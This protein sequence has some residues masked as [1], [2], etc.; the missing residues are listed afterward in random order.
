M[1]DITEFYGEIPR[2]HPRRLPP[3]YAQRCVNA[4][5]ER[6]TLSPYRTPDNTGVALGTTASTFTQFAGAF[7][8]FVGDVDAVPG[9]VA[10]DRL[11]YTGDGAPKVRQTDGT[12]FNLSLGSPSTPPATALRNNGEYLTIDG[13]NVRLAHEIRGKGTGV[14]V[15]ISVSVAYNTATVRIALHTGLNAAQVKTIID[16]LKYQN[17][18]TTDTIAKSL[19]IVR[20]TSLRDEGEQTYDEDKNALGSPVRLID[21]VG[22][23]VSV[24]GTSLS[25]E[26]P[27]PLPQ[28]GTDV[29]D[30]NDAPTII[31]SGLNPVFNAGD[32]AVALF[33]DT[34]VSAVEFGQKIVEII[35]T[36]DGLTNGVVNPNTSETLLYA[37]TYVSVLDEESQPSPLTEV[38]W[39]P[40]QTVAVTGLWGGGWWSPRVR[41]KRIYRAQTSASGTTDLYFVGEVLA[42]VGGFFDAV[43]ETPIQEPL[44][45]LDY[46]SPPDDLKGLVSLPNGMMAAFRGK[47][48]CF[49]EPWQPHAWPA[50]YRLTTDFPIVALAAAGSSLIV[51]TNGQPYLA[52]GTHPENMQIVK[53]E[54]LAPCVAKRSVVDLGY[55]VAFASTDGLV[56]IDSNGGVKFA[57]EALF[58]DKQWSAMKPTQMIAAQYQRRYALSYPH[59]GTRET[60][61]IDLSGETPFVIRTAWDAYAFHYN[62]ATGRLYYK[63]SGGAVWQADPFTGAYAMQTWRSAPVVLPVAVNMGAFLIEGDSINSKTRLI[64]KIYG[65]GRLRAT[66]SRPN[67]VVKLPSGYLAREWYVEITG[68]FQITGVHMARTTTELKQRAPG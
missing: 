47:A 58:T 29:P 49:A 53:I 67:E 43:D 60:A 19:K 46:D 24:A 28:D 65:D 36:V 39:S 61:V 62:I 63:K 64:A 22:T 66:V 2:L 21:D 16:G 35:L 26:F 40:G 18:A 12:I 44:A 34:A 31:T 5:L 56:V 51:L 17:T 68:N 20:I 54:V 50:K 45:S 57:T 33:E 59:R 11:Y 38:T 37:Y 25:Y 52:A 48:I 27:A 8:G 1:F 9:P 13:K 32:S 15:N 4:K 41:A 3:G 6:G 23:T 7:L 10:A 14:G 55:A 30:Q 42:S